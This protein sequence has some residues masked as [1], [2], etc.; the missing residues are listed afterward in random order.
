MH[1]ALCL[2]H[3]ASYSYSCPPFSQNV[4]ESQTRSSPCDVSGRALTSAWFKPWLLP[5]DFS[6][7][8]VI[9]EPQFPYLQS[10]RE[11]RRGARGPEPSQRRSSGLRGRS[12]DGASSCPPPAR[13]VFPWGSTGHFPPRPPRGA[14]SCRPRP[15]CSP[16]PPPRGSPAA[17]APW[18]E[19]GIGAWACPPAR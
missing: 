18:P 9:L 8:P 3:P 1:T 10:G 4:G 19:P 15:A 12:V 14:P 6:N 17:Q 7:T 16:P 5:R 11:M 13:G 2:L